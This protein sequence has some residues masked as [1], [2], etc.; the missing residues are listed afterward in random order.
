[1][2]E[3]IKI[4][5]T[6]ET[7]QAAADLARFVATAGSGLRSLAPAAEN[8]GE[9]LSKMRESSMLLRESFHGLS[10]ATLLLG[11]GHLRELGE[12]MLVA[13][14]GMMGLRTTAMLTGMSM[15][16]LLLPLVAIGASLVPAGVTAW[17]AYKASVAEAESALRELAQVQ[18][19]VGKNLAA[20]NL[21]LDK[22]LISGADW[23]YITRLLDLGTESALKAAQARMGELG[24]SAGQ[25][26]EYEKLLKL[27]GEMR[28][29]VMDRFD[30]ERDK[31]EA[32]FQKR[33]AEIAAEAAASKM[34]AG[35]RATAEQ[36]ARD[37]LAAK[38]DAI[39]KQQQAEAEAAAIKSI[40]DQLF[41]HERA[42]AKGSEMTAAEVYSFR[43]DRMTAAAEAGK[44]SYQQLSEY[45]L[46]EE[47][48]LDAGEKAELKT[49]EQKTKELERQ[50]VLQQEIARAQTE[51]Q[52]K[53]IKD[54]PFLNNYQKG[55]ASIPLLQTQISQN[56]QS[57]TSMAATA[58]APGTE[59]TARLEAMQKI[60]ALMGQQVTLQHQLDE[61][62]N[63]DSFNYQLGQTIVK[64]QNI[65][66]LAQSAAQAFAGVWTTATNSISQNLS[67]LVLGTEKWGQ[68]L[69]SIYNSVITEVVNQMVKM[70]VQWTLQHTLM[71]AISSLFGVGEA[72]RAASTQ[73]TVTLINAGGATERIVIRTAEAAHDTTMTGVQVAAHAG[74]ESVKTGSTLLGAV[75][76]GLIRLGE[77]IYHGVLVVMR[78]AAHILGEILS[79]AAT[80]AQAAIRALAWG[81]SAVIG[82]MSA[83]ASVPYVGPLL[84]VAAG[85][86]M[87]AAVAGA[88]GAFQDGGYT[89]DG[90]S[91]QPA[92]IV[93]RGEYVMPASAVDRIG[94][95]TLA[96]LHHGGSVPAAGSSGGSGGGAGKGVSVYSFT[97]PRQMADHL[98]KNDDHEKWVV[99]VMGRNIHKFR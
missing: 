45:I 28:V 89:G 6:A 72:A 68:A 85:A 38:G 25:I 33:M 48:K 99:D 86:A 44:I 79:T 2:S 57:M 7:A 78:T 47:R 16:A 46:G 90:A 35:E 24:V 26:S 43:V 56:D 11:G 22:G 70:V 53:A 20:A 18:E 32:N 49:A 82:A 19:L 30:Q 4:I 97:D 9:A 60:N 94:L 95:G 96:A 42:L 73:T 92:G 55:Q 76:R 91:D 5:V 12:G 51:A 1:M 58:N 3:P 13:R 29:A 88:M 10:E 98:Q 23:L 64:L 63:A 31:A 80:L 39:T 77:T 15:S 36:L 67:G 87:A 54:N 59:E 65:G 34:A 50:L 14:S 66:T 52:L 93:H 81:I 17:Q 21:A 69:R 74:G 75:Q 84:A 40:E 83:M 37:E 8:A 62:Q 61:A 41:I 71:A 27:E